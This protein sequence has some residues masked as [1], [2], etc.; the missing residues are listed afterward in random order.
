MFKIGKSH[1][2]LLAI[3]A[4]VYTAAACSTDSSVDLEAQEWLQ[5]M[6][7]RVV[8]GDTFDCS[9]GTR[10]R[11]ILVDAPEWNQGGSYGRQAHQA[12]TELLGRGAT[13]GLELDVE[14]IDPFGRLLAYVRLDDGRIANEELLRRGMAIVAVYPPNVRYLER[15]RA[16][17]EEAQRNRVG[18]WLVGGF[19]CTPAD[20]R[21]GRCSA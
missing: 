4:A 2:L 1:A 17:M 10:V 19:D 12:L 15:F 6:V 13:V 16:V 8:D 7:G 20:F 14:H 11:L 18:L 21:A 9:D 5:C 3:V